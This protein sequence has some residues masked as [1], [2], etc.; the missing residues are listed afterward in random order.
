MEQQQHD[1]QWFGSKDG[2]IRN[3]YGLPPPISGSVHGGLGLK[4]GG[5]YHSPPVPDPSQHLLLS[6]YFNPAYAAAATSVAGAK[7]ESSS[8]DASRTTTSSRDEVA[9]VSIS[10]ASDLDVTEWVEQVEPG[11]CITLRELSDGTREL[12]RVR[13]RLIIVYLIMDFSARKVFE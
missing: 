9:S 10:N 11:V 13:F 7:G 8:I 4:G 12:R 6:H 1:K 2:L 3:A 5:P